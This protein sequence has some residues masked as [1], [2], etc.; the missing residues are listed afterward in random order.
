MW[1]PFLAL[2][3]WYGFFQTPC[4]Y[5]NNEKA[6][7]VAVLGLCNILLIFFDIVF[8]CSLRI[9]ISD[10]TTRTHLHVFVPRDTM[11]D[12]TLPAKKDPGQGLQM[13]RAVGTEHKL[14]RDMAAIA[15]GCSPQG[16]WMNICSPPGKSWETRKRDSEPESQLGSHKP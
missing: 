6:I 15:A 2:A 9:P 8:V 12:E 4:Y 3:R 16:S 11:Q 1:G 14:L 7:F 13:S 5:L 10:T